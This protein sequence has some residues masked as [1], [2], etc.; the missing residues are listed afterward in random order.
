MNI[1]FDKD[2][3]STATICFHTIVDSQKPKI[4]KG[5]NFWFNTG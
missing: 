5:E 3:I 1:L 2:K 4:H